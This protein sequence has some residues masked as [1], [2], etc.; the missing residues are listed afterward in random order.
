MRATIREQI[1]MYSKIETFFR[2]ETNPAH[3]VSIADAAFYLGSDTATEQQVKDFVRKYWERGELS[4]IREGKAY[5]YWWTEGAVPH[6]EE[7]E[8]PK[9]FAVEVDTAKAVPDGDL[10]EINVNSREKYV[11][12]N[13]PSVKIRIDY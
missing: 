8:L 5:K 11:T 7:P 4:R 9:Q 1:L 3:P 12:I 6:V 13:T 2:T 10:P